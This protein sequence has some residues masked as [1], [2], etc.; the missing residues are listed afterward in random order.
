MLVEYSCKYSPQDFAG[1]AGKAGLKV[2]NS[3]TDAEQLFSLQLLS[4]A[5]G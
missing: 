1:M 2:V 5:D 3:W 4:R